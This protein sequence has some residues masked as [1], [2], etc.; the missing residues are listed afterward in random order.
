MPN[1]F[2]FRV[3]FRFETPWFLPDVSYTRRV[4]AG[5]AR[6][7]RARAWRR[8]RCCRPAA[9]APDRLVAGRACS[10]RTAER[11]ASRPRSP[12]SVELVGATGAWRG[13]AH[14]GPARRHRRDRL[15]RDARRRRSASAR[16]NPDFG[17]QV[18]GRRRPRADDPV[19]AR[20][21]DDAAAAA[22]RRRR[23][24]R[25][26]SSRRRGVAAQLPLALGRRH[27][28]PGPGRAQ[29]A[30]AQR[31]AHRSPSD[32]TTRSPTPR[33][34]R[35]TRRTP[36]ARCA[37]RTSPGSTSRT[38]RSAPLPAGFVRA[39]PVRGPRHRRRRVRIQGTAVRRP[40]AA[41]VRGD[42]RPGRRLLPRDRAGRDDHRRNEDLAA[43]VRPGRRRRA[44]QGP[45]GPRRAATPAAPRSPGTTTTPVPRPSSRCRST[46]ASPSARSSCSSRTWSAASTTT[47][48]PGHDRPA[49]RSSASRSATGSGSTGSATAAR[50]RARTAAARAGHVPRPPRV[51]D[52]A[53]HRGRRAALGDRL[54]DRRTVTERVGFDD[55]RAARAQRDPGARASSSS[56]TW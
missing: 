21:A 6:A 56:R 32:S 25:S 14:A 53:H 31:H 28:L 47:S 43:A 18:L 24:R 15:L 51:R 20:R 11:A 1:Y 30:P 50:A 19:R 52:R 44:Q 45:A 12:R 27:P 34:S 33:S 13:E 7:R 54:G 23:G 3:T 35:T 10:A 2:V 26:R 9:H 41:R 37:G 55:R 22:H 8:A 48:A 16:S 38:R 42:R 39:L 5:R 46:R 49:T 29:E 36:A 17:E 4:R 40:A